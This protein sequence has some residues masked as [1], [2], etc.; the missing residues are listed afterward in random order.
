MTVAEMLSEVDRKYPNN[1]DMAHKWG[2]IAQMEKLLLDEC[3]KTH[4]LS[5]WEEKK[6]EEI[7]SIDTPEADYC[8]LAQPPYHDLYIHYLAAQ[9]AGINAD[10]DAYANESAL[11]N[12]ALLT[13]KNAFNRTHRAADDGQRWRF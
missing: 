1:V 12:N 3:L 2:W 5:V 11:Y 13:Y 7:A 8:P 6:A 10:T 9:I 4:K